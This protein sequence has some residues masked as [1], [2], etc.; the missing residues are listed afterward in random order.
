MSDKRTKYVLGTVITSLAFVIAAAS[1]L[2][3]DYNALGL[4]EQQPVMMMGHM[5]LI[6]EGPDGIYAYMQ[7]DNVI[8]DDGLD[9]AGSELFGA[10]NDPFD[11]IHLSGNTAGTHTNPAT[12]TNLLTTT[13]TITGTYLQLSTSAQQNNCSDSITS[14]C[15]QISGSIQIGAGEATTLIKSVALANDAPKFLSWTDLPGDLQT[16]AETTTVTINYQIK[17]G[18]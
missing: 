10:Q 14:T 18:T 1:M 13:G 9:V 6:A 8:L 16:T 15:E 2:P 5:V 11:R 7:G 17:L 12:P 3:A 4:S